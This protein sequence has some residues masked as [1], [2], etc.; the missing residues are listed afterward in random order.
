MSSSSEAVQEKKVKAHSG[1]VVLAAIF[2]MFVS[3]I[4][5]IAATPLKIPGLLVLFLGV[6]FCLGFF[7]VHPNQAKVLQLFGTYKGTCIETGLRWANPFYQK[8]SVSL[9]IRNFE[10]DKSKVNDA[11]GSPIEIAAVVV[12]KVVDSAEA[13]FEVDDFE[14]YVT[15]Q[16]ESALRNL[17]NSYPYDL[18]SDDESEMTLRGDTQ[19]IAEELKQEIQERL[20]KAGVE[21][22][23]ARITHLAY[24]PEIANAML[25]RQ[26][27]T[28][29]IAA[30]TR[31]VEGAV[32]MVEMA[33]NKLSE[34]EI[35]ELDD[36]RK[37]AMV[38]NL[39]VVLC[40][41]SETQPVVNAG[42]IY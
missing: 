12:W 9:R 41:D 39:L 6:F 40:S 24:A 13:V 29:V 5:M 34:R 11:S 16:S 18:S 2:A 19:S 15:T 30:R 36:E 8:T 26:Q 3:A 10:S 35:V 31:V 37:A 32:S 33:L 7:M 27:A 42:T 38:S 20:D 21:V 4:G 1:Y 28:A 25:R 14:D 23:E 17:A 22:I